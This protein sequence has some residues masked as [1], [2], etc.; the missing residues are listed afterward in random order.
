M[1]LTEDMGAKTRFPM[2]GHN[3]SHGNSAGATRLRARL[4]ARL[5]VRQAISDDPAAIRRQVNNHAC[6]LRGPVGQRAVARYVDHTL[7]VMALNAL[8]RSSGPVQ[9]R[10]ELVDEIKLR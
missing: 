5:R 3:L 7:Q 10:A 2:V 9:W 6:G 4:R 1:A 8:V